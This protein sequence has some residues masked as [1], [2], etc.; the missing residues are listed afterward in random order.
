MNQI[1]ING[2][3]IVSNSGSISISGG[4]VTIDG[5]EV[6]G[7]ENEKTLNIEV[8]GDLESLTVDNASTIRV[9]GNAGEVVSKNGN[10]EVRG[11]VSGNVESKNGNIDCGNVGGNVETK[12]GNIK[13]RTLIPSPPVPPKNRTLKEGEEPLKPTNHE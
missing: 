13:H 11:N 7:F 10:I 9:E 8:K 4:K 3:T 6:E 1:I 12:N 5:K 2:K